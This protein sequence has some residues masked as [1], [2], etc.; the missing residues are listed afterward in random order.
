MRA[1]HQFLKHQMA[2]SV[3]CQVRLEQS[4]AEVLNIA[5]EVADDHVQARRLPETLGELPS[6]W[7]EL[8]VELKGGERP[9]LDAVDA[10]LRASGVRVAESQSK[11]GR[12]L[13]AIRDAETRKENRRREPRGA[14]ADDQ[15]RGFDPRR[16][17]G[18]QRRHWYTR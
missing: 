7:R 14:A 10:R 18:I 13:T 9:W 8:E 12:V 5:V 11:L 6:S 15:D 2:S 1:V 16:E 3:L 17:R 4:L